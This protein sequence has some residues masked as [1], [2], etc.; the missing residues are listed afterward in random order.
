M[1]QATAVNPHIAGLIE[2]QGIDAEIYTYK[3]QREELAGNLDRLKAILGQMADGLEQKRA[4]LEESEGWYRDKRL[5]LEAD[6]ERI[7]NAKSKLA[8][9]GRT[10]EYQAM[11]KELDV[12]RK[13]YTE[14]QEELERLQTAITE[15]Q[16]SVAE[17]EAKLAEIQAE[18]AR[19]EE[20]SGDRLKELDEKMASV[21][22]QKDVIVEALPVRLVRS[23][24]RILNARDGVAVTPAIAGCCSSCQMKVPPQVW[25]KV[26]IGKELFQCSNCQRYLYYNI[27]ASQDAMR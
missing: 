6:A 16:A 12:L 22:T 2:L 24:E 5:D 10:K 18:V 14:N 9:V 3:I 21:A 20:T 15:A 13:R 27:E 7:N 8:G 19:E 11:T 1:P 4:R 25:V 23:Y 26:Q 17:D